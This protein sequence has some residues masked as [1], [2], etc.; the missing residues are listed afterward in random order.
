[1]AIKH[2]AHKTP[3][4]RGLSS[5]WNDNHTID[6]D[7]DF[8][9]FEAQ[10]VALENLAAPPIA[11]ATGQIYFDTTLG[12]LRIWD[13]A[14]WLA[15][16]GIDETTLIRKDGT[17]A[18]TGN[19]SMGTHKLTNVVDPAAAQDA[20]TR[21]YVDTKS[22]KK[23]FIVVDAAGNGDYDNLRDA[24]AAAAAGGEIWIKEG[25]YALDDGTSTVYTFPS[26]LTVR[27]TG[28]GTILLTSA[29]ENYWFSFLNKSYITIEN[30]KFQILTAAGT[31]AP[32]DLD[33][34]DHI[35][36]K[37]CI[38]GFGNTNMDAI[39]WD[40]GG[41]TATNFTLQDCSVV[42]NEGGGVCVFALDMN[43]GFVSGNRMHVLDAFYDA[44]E[45]YNNCT[46]I[47]NEWANFVTTANS[48]TVTASRV[49]GN[50]TEPGHSFTFAAASNY[51]AIAGNVS[52]SAISNTG[53]GNVLAG[54]A[55]Y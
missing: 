26:N 33:N 48:T 51:N 2:I 45:N 19:Q 37:N 35:T 53:T 42:Y 9:Q 4:S 8:N 16:T 41:N 30:L 40:S 32:F 27:G 49:V 21:N 25:T 52:D 11:P 18:F 34:A 22:S 46:F 44:G 31:E 43:L 13:G 29:A 50:I 1:M 3:E 12:E 24:L 39:F 23:A 10:A 14:A 7:V 20:A 17:V 54:N 15:Y 47:N 6:G 38:F 28:V 36:I 55:V 5:E